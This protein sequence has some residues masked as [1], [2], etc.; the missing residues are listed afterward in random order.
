MT[1]CRPTASPI[2]SDWSPKAPVAAKIMPRNMKMAMTAT[3]WS[4]PFF[5]ENEGRAIM[6]TGCMDTS[7]AA[8]RAA[9]QSSF[10]SD[11]GGESYHR[12]AMLPPVRRV[13]FYGLLGGAL[14]VLLK[15]LEYQY[16]VRTY[17][18]EIYGGLVA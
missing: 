17:P 6:A 5:H 3:P 9:E 4:N 7:Q 12:P 16:V 10:K 15:V 1:I 14:L 18:G 2:F 8:A 13:I 11:P